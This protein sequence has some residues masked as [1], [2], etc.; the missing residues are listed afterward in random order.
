MFTKRNL[1][2]KKMI[3]ALMFSALQVSANADAGSNATASVLEGL[4][5]VKSAV[6]INGGAGENCL[7]GLL[8]AVVVTPDKILLESISAESSQKAFETVSK[9]YKTVLR[10]SDKVLVVLR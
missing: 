8:I 3:F 7:N 10:S 2:M 5:C 4:K 9:T 6:G 1:S